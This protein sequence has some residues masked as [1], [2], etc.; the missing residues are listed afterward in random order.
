MVLY[1]FPHLGSP[2]FFFGLVTSANHFVA[3]TDFLRVT[4]QQHR[5]LYKLKLQ[6]SMLKRR[7]FLQK[8]ERAYML[9]VHEKGPMK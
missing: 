2:L 5:I 4:V 9:K 8:Y 6:H 1:T 7:R 3:A